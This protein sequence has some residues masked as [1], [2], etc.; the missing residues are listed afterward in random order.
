MLQKL[1]SFGCATSAVAIL[2]LAGCS[3]VIGLERGI[4]ATSCTSSRECAPHQTCRNDSCWSK[5]GGDEECGESETCHD[6]I[7]LLGE[8]VPGDRQCAG[9]TP[10]ACNNEQRWVDLDERCEMACD[11]GKCIRRPSCDFDQT[12]GDEQNS[13]CLADAIPGGT[14]E[15]PYDDMDTRVSVQI[16]VEPF[17][18][19]RFEV[20]ITKSSRFN[21]MTTDTRIAE[22]LG[23]YRADSTPPK[24]RGVKSIVAASAISLAVGM[25]VG[26][27]I[28]SKH[29]PVTMIPCDESKCDTLAA[30]LG[31]ANPSCRNTQCG[32]F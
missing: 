5:C 22:G 26:Y 21:P 4:A 24:N 14:F 13:C 32:C 8:C 31:C 15:L 20:T 23:S 17:A 1:S 29:G 7:C 12:C 28:G 16:E 11:R 19:D 6:G 2:A 27:A 10:Q 25:T 9:L 30:Y 3:D 18:L